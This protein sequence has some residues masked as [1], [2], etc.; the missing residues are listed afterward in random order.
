MK[1]PELLDEVEVWADGEWHT[2]YIERLEM[3]GVQVD[4][5]KVRRDRNDE[6]HAIN[7]DMYMDFCHGETLRNGHWRY[8]NDA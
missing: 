3:V 8:A 4:Q 1:Q 6:R 7:P 2:A 5:I